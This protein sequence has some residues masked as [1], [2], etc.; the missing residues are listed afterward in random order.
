MFFF[1]QRYL[2]YQKLNYSNRIS[3]SFSLSLFLTSFIFNFVHFFDDPF[4]FS[5]LVSFRCS[6]QKSFPFSIICRDGPSAIDFSR[7]T[8]LPATEPEGKRGVRSGKRST[9]IWHEAR[10]WLPAPLS[11]F[12]LFFFFF[13]TLVAFRPQ[14]SNESVS[15]RRRK[16]RENEHGENG[17]YPLGKTTDR[18]FF[19]FQRFNIERFARLPCSPSLPMRSLFPFHFHSP[20]TY[21]RIPVHRIRETRRRCNACVLLGIYDASDI[22][23]ERKVVHVCTLICLVRILISNS[24]EISPTHFFIPLFFPSIFHV[25]FID[26]NVTIGSLVAKF[27]KLF[28]DSVKTGE[29]KPVESLSAEREKRRENI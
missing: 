1:F 21:A 9:T 25:R 29:R 20:Y 24:L 5:I 28:L 13:S 14:R 10:R 19:P 22:R 11:P 23:M 2:I 6:L 27:W 3:F 12:L 17:I 7:G 18:G 15:T 26:K 8:W 16:F 4:A